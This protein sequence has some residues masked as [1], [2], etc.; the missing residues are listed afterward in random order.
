MKG[1]ADDKEK[2][3]KS[4]TKSDGVV[5]EGSRRGSTSA[6]YPVDR[7]WSRRNGAGS[8]P[9]SRLCNC[10]SKQPKDNFHRRI[11]CLELLGRTDD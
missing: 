8:P 10:H 11:K 6:D 7:A 5:S 1:R 3:D 9:V 4:R 2:V